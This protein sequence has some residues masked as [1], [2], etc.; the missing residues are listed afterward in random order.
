MNGEFRVFID[1]GQLNQ[2]KNGVRQK[3]KGGKIM[4]IKCGCHHQNIGDDVT[5]IFVLTTAP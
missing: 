3:Q 4:R 2:S 1:N 5:H